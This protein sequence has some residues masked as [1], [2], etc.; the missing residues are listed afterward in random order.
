MHGTRELLNRSRTVL[1]MFYPP[2]L[3]LARGRRVCDE[4]SKTKKVLP[5]ESSSDDG[6]TFYCTVGA[7]VLDLRYF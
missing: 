6:L 2:S 5:Y 4:Y 7:V 3:A 1:G